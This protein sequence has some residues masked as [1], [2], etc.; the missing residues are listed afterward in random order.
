MIKVESALLTHSLKSDMCLMLRMQP[1]S[2]SLCFKILREPHAGAASWNSIVLTVTS[3][4]GCELCETLYDLGMLSISVI[5]TTQET[6]TGRCQ[7]RG[8]SGLYSYFKAL[9]QLMRS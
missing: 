2:D 4:I 9:R 3:S 7:V 1:S 5:P 8:L 6:E